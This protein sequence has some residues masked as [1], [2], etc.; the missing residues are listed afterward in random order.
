MK[1]G[2]V[3]IKDNTGISGLKKKKRLLT[4]RRGRRKPIPAVSPTRCRDNSG[5]GG[6]VR[7]CGR[8]ARCRSAASPAGWAERPASS[9]LPPHLQ[10]QTAPRCSWSSGQTPH[11]SAGIPAPGVPLWSSATVPGRRSGRRCDSSAWHHQ[12]RA[13]EARQTFTCS[14]VLFC[15]R[16]IWLL[17]LWLAAK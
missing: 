4:Q 1:Y 12:R 5:A 14:Q 17:W 3:T 10:Q 11:L 7:S 13:L 2:T 9:P 6:T 16:G 8:S 15:R